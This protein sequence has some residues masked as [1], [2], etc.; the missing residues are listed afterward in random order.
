MTARPTL[1]AGLAGLALAAVGAVAAQGDMHLSADLDEPAAL[2]QLMMK[3]VG[4]AMK[5]MGD[6]A[7]GETEFEPRVA[8]GALHTMQGVA[9][10]FPAHF[11]DGSDTGAKTEAAP[12]IWS[13]RAGFEEAA[14]AMIEA[15]A[16][17]LESPPQDLDGLKATLGKLGKTCKSCHEDYRIKKE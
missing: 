14:M 13:D 3:Q 5:L 15:S 1:R 11:P 2:R 16:A 12:A 4:G 8:L 10:G 7:K 9:L 17:G 6:M